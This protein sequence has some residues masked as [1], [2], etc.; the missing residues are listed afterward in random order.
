MEPAKRGCG[1]F[2]FGVGI[3]KQIQTIH[4]ERAYTSPIWYTPKG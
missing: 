2:R 3:P 1:A 4:Q